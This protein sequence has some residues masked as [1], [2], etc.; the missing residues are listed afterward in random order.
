MNELKTQSAVGSTRLL[1]ADEV[2]PGEEAEEK[3][4]KRE[5]GVDFDGMMWLTPRMQRIAARIAQSWKDQE[6]ANNRI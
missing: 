2:W 6:A 4:W 1:A 5:N 3:R